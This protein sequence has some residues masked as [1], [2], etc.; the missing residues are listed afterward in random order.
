MPF[1]L[2]RLLQKTP[3]V[4]VVEQPKEEPTTSSAQ[5]V[6]VEPVQ[7]LTLEQIIQEITIPTYEEPDSEPEIHITLPPKRKR[8]NEDIQRKVRLNPLSDK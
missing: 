7:E 8:K 3:K 4:I 1:N 2:K 6:N 5:S